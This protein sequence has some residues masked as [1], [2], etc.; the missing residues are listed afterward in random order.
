[1]GDSDKALLLALAHYLAET[2]DKDEIRRG[3][4]AW[5]ADAAQA[6]AEPQQLLVAFKNILL[7]LSIDQQADSHEQR[8]ADQRELIALCIEEYYRPA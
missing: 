8:L 3:V 6:G 2:R 1:M 7:E 4:A 5:R